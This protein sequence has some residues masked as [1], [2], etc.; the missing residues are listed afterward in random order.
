MSENYNLIQFHPL[1]KKSYII[2]SFYELPIL[3]FT[4]FLLDKFFNV[5]IDKFEFNLDTSHIYTYYTNK[6]LFVDLTGAKLHR[7]VIN[8]SSEIDLTLFEKIET[9]INFHKYSYSKIILLFT[10]RTHILGDGLIGFKQLFPRFFE[11]LVPG[12]FF[13]TYPFGVI[14]EP[15]KENLF[16]SITAQKLI[17]LSKSDG[18]L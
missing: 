12:M 4:Q 3:P 7:W 10:I 5:Q 18:L 15:N 11:Y 9:N 2:G 13:L 8:S 1:I 14:K 6:I 16:S 17:Y